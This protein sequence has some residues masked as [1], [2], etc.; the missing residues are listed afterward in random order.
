MRDEVL[1]ELDYVERDHGV[2]LNFAVE[3]GSL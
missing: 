3:S 1:Y 2:T